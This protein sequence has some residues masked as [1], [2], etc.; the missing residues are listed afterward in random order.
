MDK[1]VARLTPAVISARL[2]RLP[3]T[4]SV[5]LLLL[6]LAL[7]GFF[8]QYDLYFSGYIAPALVQNNLLTTSTAAFFG[9]T[10][11]AGFLASVFIGLLIGT[12]VFGFVADR[13]GR[14]TVFTA[15][16]LWYSAATLI[17]AFQHTAQGLNIWRLISGIGIG[18]EVVTI[19]SYVSEIT[20][21]TARG[22]AFGLVY[23][24]AQIC[25]PVI[26][27]LAWLLV[28]IAPFGISGW[29]WIVVLGSVGAIAVW[30]LRLGL[31]E[32]PRWLAQQ[33]RLEEAERVVERIEA[34]VRRE[35]G[36]ELPPYT[37]E[38]EENTERSRFLEVFSPAYRGRTIMLMIVNFF[39]TIGYYGFVSWIPTLLIAKN[40]MVTKSLEYTFLIVIAYPLAPLLVMKIADRFERKRQ[41][42][43]SAVAVAAIGILFSRLD[44]P[45]WLIVVGFAQT[46]AVN[47]MSTMI[48]AYQAELFPTRM[49]AQAVG[50]V[51]AWSRLSSIFTGFF[52]AFFL[53]DFG[54]PAVFIFISGAM[55][56]LV[57]AVALLGPRVTGRGLEEI[58]S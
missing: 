29:R 6:V 32:S 43:L 48:H 23:G 42:M 41:L 49:R 56:I 40:I 34:K 28:P 31:P 22:K 30:L 53:R 36:K 2:D 3:M 18:V 39:Q 7:G 8:E 27:F 14:R 1:P 52:I 57:L 51:Y 4:R 38:F 20:P 25:A 54:V 55:G 9:M 11:V 47:W 15:S 24:V 13:Y 26:A 33:G 46:L 12:A 58:A 10:G 19:D 44:L 35:Y 21:R 16:L 45:V 17:L 50:F 37:V 5:W